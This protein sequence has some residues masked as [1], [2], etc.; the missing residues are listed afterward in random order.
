MHGKRSRQNVT[1]VKIKLQ[2]RKG[3]HAPIVPVVIPS[4]EAI[5]GVAKALQ[6]RASTGLARYS[7]GLRNTPPKS[8]RPLWTQK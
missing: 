7:D 5:E 6:S 3:E 8:P 1:T 4:I 2:A